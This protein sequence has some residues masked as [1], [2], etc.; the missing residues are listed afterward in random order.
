V[1]KSLPYQVRVQHCNTLWL[2]GAL[3]TAPAP[4]GRSTAAGPRARIGNESSLPAA[5]APPP[6]ATPR[7]STST[8][9]TTASSRDSQGHDG[10]VVVS[11]S[12]T[13]GLHLQPGVLDVPEGMSYA[14]VMRLM[15]DGET[16]GSCCLVSFHGRRFV[17][18]SHASA[19]ASASASAS[20]EP[21]TP[22]SDAGSDSC[23]SEG[24]QLP[25]KA[26]TTDTVRG[27]RTLSWRSPPRRGSTSPRQL[28]VC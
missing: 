11:L 24:E 3:F 1:T 25:A 13:H 8:T 26:Q 21:S 9:A 19:R 18:A 28:Q 23:S 27:P 12:D 16:V 5:D 14:N 22:S 15:E 7:A 17:L 10:C 20:P 4:P 2:L 6:L